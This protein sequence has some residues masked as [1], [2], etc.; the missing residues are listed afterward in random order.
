MQSVYIMYS[1]MS[2]EWVTV[3]VWLANPPL[4]QGLTYFLKKFLR[5][6]TLRLG[7]RMGKAKKHDSS[8]S[9]HLTVWSIRPWTRAL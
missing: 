4:I 3:N 6:A 2:I 5:S 7:S 8:G 9:F 1:L